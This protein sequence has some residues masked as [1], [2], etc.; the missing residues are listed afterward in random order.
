MGQSR[1]CGKDVEGG[2]AGS[3]HVRKADRRGVMFEGRK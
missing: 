2:D 1:G 3:E